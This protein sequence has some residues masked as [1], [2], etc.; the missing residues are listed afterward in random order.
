MS[1]REKKLLIFFGLAGFVIVNF[2]AFNFASTKRIDVNAQRTDA[3]QKLA[4]AEMFQESRE[5]VTDEMEWLAKHEPEPAA[6]QDVQT[7]LQ[8]IV[9]REAKAVGLT[10]KPGQKPLPTDTT[11]THF[12]RAKIQITVTGPEDALYR[13][14]DKLNVPDQLRISSQIRLSPNPQDDTKIDCTATIE[15]WFVPKTI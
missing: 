2:L 7:S 1:P 15:Q 11:G 4:Q 9:E 6:N 13:W 3:E 12:H 5:Q 10:I 14:F 8:Q